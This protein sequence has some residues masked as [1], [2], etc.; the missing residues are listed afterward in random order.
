MLGTNS[1]NPDGSV[2]F[3]TA[4]I[5]H[6]SGR[7]MVAGPASFTTSALW[8]AASTHFQDLI[9]YSSLLNEMH[10]IMHELPFSA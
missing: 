7:L 2:S 4:D 10:E 9:I 8:G 1:V 6:L 5:L 3:R